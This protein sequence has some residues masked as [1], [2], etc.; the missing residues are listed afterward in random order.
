MMWFQI[1][2]GYH[3]MKHNSAITRQNLGIKMQDKIFSLHLPFI[4]KSLK[5]AC[6]R[7]SLIGKRSFAMPIAH[8]LGFSM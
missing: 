6:D 1:F 5:E 8:H 7:Q 3:E 4:V 2:N